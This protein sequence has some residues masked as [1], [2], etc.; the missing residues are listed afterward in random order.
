[1][2]Q[3]EC[4]RPVCEPD[5]KKTVPLRS[6]TPYRKGDQKP[7]EPGPKPVIQTTETDPVPTRLDLKMLDLSWTTITEAQE[8][9]ATLKEIFKLLRDPDPLLK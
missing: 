2:R 8:T 4:T 3:Q 5:Q 1:M 6:G 7:R 9:D